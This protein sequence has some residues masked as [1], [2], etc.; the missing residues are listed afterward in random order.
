MGRHTRLLAFTAVLI[1][2]VPGLVA[3]TSVHGG[4]GRQAALACGGTVTTSVTLTGDLNCSGS[5]GLDAGANGII[6]NLNGHTITG[7]GTHYGVLDNGFTRVV[8]ENGVINQFLHDVFIEG[9]ATGS[10]VQGMRLS[11]ASES[12]RV[13]LSTSV[14]VTGNDVGGNTAGIVIASNGDTVTANLAE[15]NTGNGVVINGQN[16]TVS[17]NKSM[18]NGAFGFYIQS[19]TGKVTGNVAN[20]NAVDGFFLDNPAS[21]GVKSGL[22]VSK[23]RASFNT[24]YGFNATPFGASDGGGNVVQRNGNAN[25]CVSIVCTEVSG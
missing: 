9:S 14:L 20:G 21:P 4:A 22:A 13:N 2:A 15:Q 11:L 5:D 16:D 3:A 25:A 12:I 24:G 1:V 6:I 10:K 23:N 18:N 8:I 19:S 7:D 17:G